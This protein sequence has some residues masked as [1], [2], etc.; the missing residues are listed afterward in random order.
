MLAAAA[1]AAALYSSA[2]HLYSLAKTDSARDAPTATW[3][4]L[5]DAFDPV[6]AANP[7]AKIVIIPA[8]DHE[9]F[10]AKTGGRDEVPRLDRIPPRAFEPTIDWILAQR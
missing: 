9:G 10:V 7:R 5:N 1:L 8:I 3:W 6:A 4:R 2:N